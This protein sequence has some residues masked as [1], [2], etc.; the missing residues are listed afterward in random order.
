MYGLSFEVYSGYY[1]DNVSWFS[2]TP[3]ASGSSAGLSSV[4]L[5]TSGFSVNTM[6]PVSGVGTLF[7][8]RLAGTLVAQATGAHAVLLSS[9][10]S[11]FLWLGANA[12]APSASNALVPNGGLHAM[13]AARASVNL[14]AGVAYPLLVVYG[15][16]F[17]SYGLTVAITQP[18]GTPVPAKALTH[19]VPSP[20]PPRPPP[21]PPLRLGA[22][23]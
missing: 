11:S 15:Q 2:G 21:R 5:A 10:D 3:V 23:F 18:D 6:Q 20:P 7:S 17:G 22:A 19:A 13:R 8:L 14:T 16:N 4:A 12:T 9:D 1:A